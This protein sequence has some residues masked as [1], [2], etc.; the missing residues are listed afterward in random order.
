[1]S[2]TKF[3]L[4]EELISWLI[5]STRPYVGLIFR[6]YKKERLLELLPIAK[7]QLKLALAQNTNNLIV[8]YGFEY[9]KRIILKKLF[10]GKTFIFL[11]FSLSKNTLCKFLQEAAKADIW[12]WSFREQELAMP[13]SFYKAAKILRIEDG[14]IRSI[15][16]GAGG[17][18]PFSYCM[19]KSGLYF[20]AS[21]ASDHEKL[22]NTFSFSS[23]P[24]LMKTAQLA[25]NFIVEH[26]LTKYNFQDNKASILKQETKQKA[27]VLVIGQ[28]EG[29]QSLLRNPDGLCRNDALLE[30][31]IA[32]HP[33]AEI[34]YR[35][36]PDVKAG[37]RPQVSNPDALLPQFSYELSDVPL[38]LSIKCSDYV[39]TIS[40]L[41][42]FE[43]LLAGKTVFTYGAPFYAGWGLTVDALTF[44][45]RQ[46]KL[47]LLEL[48]AITY[49]IYPIYFDPDTGKKLVL[50]E[51]LDRIHRLRD[52]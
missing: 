6:R 9:E 26:G 38:S 34:I 33:E 3:F 4:G 14:F 30:K 2:K 24:D 28:V 29:D 15:G 22:C 31:A 21:A 20:D 45:R 5:S 42:G 17:A 48:F 11:S 12:V 35:K 44:P 41:V 23:Q 10:P 32:K 51:V 49:L 43:A 19:D 47:T 1:M 7:L 8:A 46:R 16:L 36:H 27:R 52:T 37:H 18:K 13:P 25:L 40:S 50:T 39:Y